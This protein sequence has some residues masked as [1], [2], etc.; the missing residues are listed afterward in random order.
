MGMLIQGKWEA[1][2]EQAM[3]EQGQ[4]IR[5]T[6]GFRDWISVAGTT[7]FKAE[8]NRYHLYVAKI[9]PWACRTILMRALKGLDSVISLSYVDK[10]PT[11]AALGWAFYADKS[12]EA[13]DV[14]YGLDLLSA[15]YVKANPQYTGRVTVP[16]LWDKKT[17][18]IVNNESSE[19]VQM[20]NSGFN[21]LAENKSDFYPD[22]LKLAIDEMNQFLYESINNGVYQCGLARSQSAYDIACDRLFTALDRL[23]D[24]LATK[25]YLFGTRLTISDIFLFS[26]LIRFDL[27]YYHYF[28]CNRYRLEDYANLSGYLRDLYQTPGFSESV[29]L[30]FIKHRYYAGGLVDGA[31]AHIVPQGPL[32]DFSRSHNR[33]GLMGG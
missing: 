15:L 1:K 32:V 23:E 29:D 6:P 4:L 11:R 16:V 26:T 21:N 31:T 28:K 9:C 7:P 12:A 33:G 2:A 14:L 3:D 18:T 10:D 27:V 8:P 13:Y 25:R 5:S 17:E 22:D 19:I 20:F 30:P 24:R